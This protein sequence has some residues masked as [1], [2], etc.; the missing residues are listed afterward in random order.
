[1]KILLMGAL[2]SSVSFMA[3]AEDFTVHMKFNEDSGAVYFEPRKL[4]IKKGDT[5]T[6]V[7]KDPYNVHNIMFEPNGVP[8]NAKIPMMSPEEMNEGDS[9]KVTFNQSGSYAYHCH[10]HYDAGM[11]GEIIVDRPSTPEE[12]STAP[13]MGHHHAEGSSPNHH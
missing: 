7:H 10:P 12:K 8:K 9:W 4:E 1:M 13:A 3:Q 2:L 6:F 11:M 5:V